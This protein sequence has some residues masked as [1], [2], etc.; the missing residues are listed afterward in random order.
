MFCR[1]RLR[2]FSK[3]AR[4]PSHAYCGEIHFAGMDLM[5]VLFVELSPDARVKGLAVQIER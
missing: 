1:R 4:N 3:M 5:A 2:A